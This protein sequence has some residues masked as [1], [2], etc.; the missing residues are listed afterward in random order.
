MNTIK[1]GM[2]ID[3]WRLNDIKNPEREWTS[4]DGEFYKDCY[5]FSSN[6]KKIKLF[7]INAK[8]NVKIFDENLK[9]H[10]YYEGTIIDTRENGFFKP[11]HKFHLKK[12]KILLNDGSIEFCYKNQLQ[13]VE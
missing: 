9:Q 3:F 1:N 7:P 11:G 10:V 13:I 12:H 2:N 5:N 4:P 6:M 8:V